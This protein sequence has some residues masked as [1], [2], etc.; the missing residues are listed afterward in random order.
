[1]I[2]PTE[3][4]GLDGRKTELLLAI[5]LV[6]VVAVV[7]RTAWVRNTIRC[8]CYCNLLNARLLSRICGTLIEGNLAGVR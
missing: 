1:L 6:V 8:G 4:D 2:R 3:L 7:L 5:G